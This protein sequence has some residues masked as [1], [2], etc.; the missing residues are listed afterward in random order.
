LFAGMVSA[1]M[2]PIPDGRPVGLA[3][4]AG[5]PHARGHLYSNARFG[6]QNARFGGDDVLSHRVHKSYSFICTRA[7]GPVHRVSGWPE[8]R[9]N[10][11]I[12]KPKDGWSIA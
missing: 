12:H 9:R 8:I 11:F 6:K 7:V 5:Y 10:S 4:L 3:R 1:C 2:A